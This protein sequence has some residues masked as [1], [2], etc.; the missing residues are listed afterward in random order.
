MI[1]RIGFKKYK[2][3]RINTYTPTKCLTENEMAMLKEEIAFQPKKEEYF[4]V[5]M[6]TLLQYYGC[7]T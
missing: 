6:Q 5:R 1:T 7:I 4:N 3:T 2:Y